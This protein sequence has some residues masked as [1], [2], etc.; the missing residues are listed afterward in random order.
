LKFQLYTKKLYHQ[1]CFSNLLYT[2]FF[3]YLPPFILKRCYLNCVNSCPMFQK[4]HVVS[5]SLEV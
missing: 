3:L 4:G 5:A 1:V 2:S